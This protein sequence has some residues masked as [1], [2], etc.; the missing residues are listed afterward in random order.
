MEIEP[1][2]GGYIYR[3]LRNEKQTYR[4]ISDVTIGFGDEDANISDKTDL[5]YRL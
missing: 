3:L 2:K 5:Q 1:I 4:L